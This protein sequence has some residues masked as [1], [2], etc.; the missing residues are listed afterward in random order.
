[1]K[2]KNGRSRTSPLTERALGILRRL[3]QDA[4]ED[5]LIFDPV[6]QRLRDA[7]DSREEGKRPIS[8]TP[9]LRQ[10]AKRA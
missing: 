10:V 1:M 5:E 9:T 7:A 3:R 8:A 2:A 4:P 6:P